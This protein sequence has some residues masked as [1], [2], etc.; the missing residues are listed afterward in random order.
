MTELETTNFKVDSTWRK[1]KEFTWYVKWKKT[2]IKCKVNKEWD[3]REYVSWVPEELIWE[4]LFT[5][6]ALCRLWVEKRLPTF[7]QIKEMKEPSLAGYWIPNSK[8][9]SSIGERSNMWLAGGNNAHFN[10]NKWGRNDYNRSCGFSWRLLK[11]NEE[12]KDISW[13]EWLYKVSNLWNICSLEKISFNWKWEY[14]IKEKILK[15]QINRWWYYQLQL[16]KKWKVKTFRVHSLVAK[17]F[18]PNPNNK[19]EINHINSIRTDNRVENLEWCTT[20]ENAIHWV[21]Y[22][23]RV[24][25]KRLLKELD[26]S[27]NSSIWLF[28]KLVERAEKYWAKLW[29]SAW[30]ELGKLLDTK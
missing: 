23:N 7:E 4:Q 3:I 1:V 26:Q 20:S 21:K 28:E 11:N 10:Q 15:C 8:K 2:K 29:A 24:W 17:E 14:T 25:K 18:I 30:Y 12:R 6:N 22:W 5:Y 19:K 27:D 16:S 9:F 13:Y